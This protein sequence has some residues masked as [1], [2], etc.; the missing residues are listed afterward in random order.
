MCRPPTQEKPP[1]LPPAAGSSG[2]EQPA[3]SFS[4]LPLPHPLVKQMIAQY[5]KH[6]RKDGVYLGLGDLALF[7]RQEEVAVL[8]HHWVEKTWGQP[9]P[10]SL[11][12]RLQNV[13]GDT[14]E[15]VDGSH[16]S[17]TWVVSFTSSTFARGSFFSLNHAMPLL[18]KEQIGDEW[19]KVT[20]ATMTKMKGKLT[21]VKKKLEAWSEDSEDEA[22]HES[23]VMRLEFLEQK[24]LFYQALISDGYFPVD[25]PGDGNCLLWSMAC[26]RLGPG[27]LKKGPGEKEIAQMRK[28]CGCQSDRKTIY[29]DSLWVIVVELE[30]L[31]RNIKQVVYGQLLVDVGFGTLNL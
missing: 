27:S 4:D 23:M 16:S 15:F 17:K 26:L 14:S 30:E 22:L 8:T 3:L 31:F 24:N 13:T 9:G 7:A 10:I 28:A 18:H 21:K 29:I 20:S 11:N 25:V 12:Q 19:E 5:A 2:A 1:M 6:I